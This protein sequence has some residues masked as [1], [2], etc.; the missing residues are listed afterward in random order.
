[1]ITLRHVAEWPHPYETGLV[2]VSQMWQLGTVTRIA[3]S[4]LTQ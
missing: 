4:L 1:M 3:S 2:N